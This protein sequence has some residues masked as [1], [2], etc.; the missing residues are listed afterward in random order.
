M[1]DG[2]NLD[3]RSRS[4]DDDIGVRFPPGLGLIPPRDVP[5]QRRRAPEL[6]A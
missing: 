4:T 3:F 5:R 6:A 1:T 2:F